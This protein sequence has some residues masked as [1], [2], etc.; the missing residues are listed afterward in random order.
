MRLYLYIQ[1]EYCTTTLARLISEKILPGTEVGMWT[2]IEEILEGLAH[3][4]SRDVIHRD[5]KPSNI[6]VEG[7]HI[8]I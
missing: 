8:D 6:F 3:I 4:H 5:L 1:M 2:L 7:G